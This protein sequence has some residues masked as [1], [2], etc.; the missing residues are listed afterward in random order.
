MG[1]TSV[2]ASTDCRRAFLNE[3]LITIVIHLQTAGGI[4]I[5]MAS[6]LTID[7]QRAIVYPYRRGN[8]YAIISCAGQHSSHAHTTT[9]TIQG[10]ESS[11]DKGATE[12]VWNENKQLHVQLHDTHE[13]SIHVYWNQECLC[14]AIV[15]LKEE[16]QEIE[17]YAL[18]ASPYRTCGSVMLK[19]SWSRGPQIRS[20]A[21]DLTDT[22]I[23]VNE[24]PLWEGPMRH[25]QQ[26]QQAVSGNYGA[27]PPPVSHHQPIVNLQQQQQQQHIPQP[28]PNP[29]Q[30]FINPTH[31]MQ[32]PQYGGNQQGGQGNPPGGGN[33]HGRGQPPGGGNQ[34]GRG[35]PPGGGYQHGRGYARGGSNHYGGW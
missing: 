17:C 19:Y 4:I 10:M 3:C 34:H 9:S 27:H 29:P 14:S 11:S 16:N 21:P 13:I 25:L 30:Q 22:P 7:L 31:H 28:H 6:T 26:A 20:K 18:K 12:L 15:P 1:I 2:A 35:Y 8:W 33:Q 5:V 24:R 23:Y 32:Q